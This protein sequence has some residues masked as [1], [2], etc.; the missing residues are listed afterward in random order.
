MKKITGQGLNNIM[1]GGIFSWMV[2]L[3]G[4]LPH[5]LLYNVRNT[6]CIFLLWSFHH[7]FVEQMTTGLVGGC[8]S[9]HFWGRD[10][11]PARHNFFIRE[12]IFQSSKGQILLSLC[13]LCKTDEA[14]NKQYCYICMCMCVYIYS[15]HLGIYVAEW[16]GL[17]SHVTTYD[18]DQYCSTGS[19]W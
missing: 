11:W 1:E 14:F 13:G 8:W 17:I 16:W 6:Q 18:K 5:I 9:I 7:V 4:V 2:F 19:T 10:Q 12:Y 3:K 15:L